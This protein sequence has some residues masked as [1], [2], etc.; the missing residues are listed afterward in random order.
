MTRRRFIVRGRVQGV[1]FRWFA[2]HWAGKL[3][4]RGWAINREDG[5]MEAE[6]EGRRR[7][8]EEFARQLRAGPSAA[9]VEEVETTALE[10]E[11]GPPF[12]DIL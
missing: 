8:V 4:L 11:G 6:A 2:R 10:P 7:D 1:G 5:T 12:F 3:G 9:C